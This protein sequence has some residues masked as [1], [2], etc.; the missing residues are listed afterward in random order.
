MRP[1]NFPGRKNAR[2]IQALA[3][4]NQRNRMMRRGMTPG[5]CKEIFVLEQR[6]VGSAAARAVRTKKRRALSK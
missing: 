4:L 5:E 6:I 1:K 2:R 3:K